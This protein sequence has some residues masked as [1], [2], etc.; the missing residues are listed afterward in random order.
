MVWFFR[1]FFFLFLLFLFSTF[2][3]FLPC[4]FLVCRS[5]GFQS[6]FLSVLQKDSSFPFPKFFFF[7]IS[8]FFTA[9]L[10]TRTNDKD[11][12]GCFAYYC[13]PLLSNVGPDLPFSFGFI[14][15]RFSCPIIDAVS[16]FSY[17]AH[18]FIALSSFFPPSLH[19]LFCVCFTPPSA[20]LYFGAHLRFLFWTIF[21]SYLSSTFFFKSHT[22]STSRRFVFF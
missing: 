20:F 13:A 10:D 2:P 1:H 21:R 11:T 8:V 15:V 6:Y 5:S 4:D 18:G 7:S 19:C 22:S 3:T 16:L 12:A 14:I 17:G 9:S